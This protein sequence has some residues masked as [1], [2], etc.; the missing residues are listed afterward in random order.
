MRYAVL[1]LL[2]PGLGEFVQGRH[3]L[4]AFTFF[5][6]CSV[7]ATGLGWLIVAAHLLSAIIAGSL[8]AER[9]C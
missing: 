7:W 3:A 2:V 5:T 9:A 8:A 1:S 4:G 6:A